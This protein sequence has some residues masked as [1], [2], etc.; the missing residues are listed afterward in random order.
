MALGGEDEDP[1]ELPAEGGPDEASQAPV[2]PGESHEAD[3]DDRPEASGNQG[4]PHSRQPGR[5]LDGLR[6]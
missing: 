5:D 1:D 2:P 4:P 3:D 6:R